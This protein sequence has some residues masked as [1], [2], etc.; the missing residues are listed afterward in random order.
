M[1]DPDVAA[2]QRLAKLGRLVVDGVVTM[3]EAI[4]RVRKDRGLLSGGSVTEVAEGGWTAAK[5]HRHIGCLVAWLLHE[6]VLRHAAD[7]PLAAYASGRAFVKIG[8]AHV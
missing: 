7:D 5:T 6:W 2:G 3:G 4:T 1:T 8:R